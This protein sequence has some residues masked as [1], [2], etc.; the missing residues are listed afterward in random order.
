MNKPLDIKDLIATVKAGSAVKDMLLTASQIFD[1]LKLKFHA[2]Y[3]SRQHVL[4][5]KELSLCAESL[6]SLE[7][8]DDEG[9]LLDDFNEIV[10]RLLDW[11]ESK[12][13]S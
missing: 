3:F 2:G 5:D 12:G 10:E 1:A 9:E 7:E 4:Y 13:I 8:V 11:M 6:I